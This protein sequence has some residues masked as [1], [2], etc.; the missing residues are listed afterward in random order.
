MAPQRLW[1]LCSPFGVTG[2]ADWL[3]P[4]E[5]RHRTQLVHQMVGRVGVS[6]ACEMR[7]T[8]RLIGYS[9]PDRIQLI[10]YS[11][12][13]GP[14]NFELRRLGCMSDIERVRNESIRAG[15][16]A[17]ADGA[18]GPVEHGDWRDWFAWAGYRAQKWAHG[19]DARRVT[20]RPCYLAPRLADCV[21]LPCAVC[22][23]LSTSPREGQNPW[24]WALSVPL[25]TDPAPAPR[26]V[27]DPAEEP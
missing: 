6:C 8:F 26:L 9:L 16:Q 20:H 3:R 21:Q 15:R 19:F 7:P 23:P 24:E 18:L 1:R 2:S 11:L 4:A 14:C 22:V 25:E 17:C 12:R 10:G 13:I 27:A 5:S